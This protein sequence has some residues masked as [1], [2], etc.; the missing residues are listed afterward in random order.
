MSTLHPSSV[1]RPIEQPVS[2]APGQS[3]ITGTPSASPVAQADSITNPTVAGNGYYKQEFMIHEKGQYNDYQPTMAPIIYWPIGPSKPSV[4]AP[5][6]ASPTQPAQ[7]ISSGVIGGRAYFD[8]YTSGNFDE[9]DYGIP[10]V[11]VWLF[12]CGGTFIAGVKTSNGGYFTFESLPGGNYVVVIQ[13][14]PGYVSATETSLTSLF[15]TNQVPGVKEGQI[16]Q[17]K[18]QTRMPDDTI[19]STVCFTIREGETSNVELSF[20]MQLAPTSSPTFLPSSDPT[21]RPSMSYKP[22][23]QEPTMLPSR[24]P[25]TRPVPTPPPS[26]SPQSPPTPPTYPIL[27][28]EEVGPI[29]TNKLSITLFGIDEVGTP[30]EWSDIHARYI[31]Q[32]FNSEEWDCK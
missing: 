25:T 3:S 15:T 20:G 23:S 14:P 28:G 21:Y 30:E 29:Q 1:S 4:T 10:N 27:D 18:S 22:S 12:T 7:P 5:T 6:P 26:L 31:N 19:C 24:A 2:Q 32:Y 9:E 11:N 13:L 17:H 16:S 8:M